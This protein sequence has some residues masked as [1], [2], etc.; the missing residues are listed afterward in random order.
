MRLII[1]QPRHEDQIEIER[2]RHA[3][4][5]QFLILQSMPSSHLPEQLILN[6]TGFNEDVTDFFDLDDEDSSQGQTLNDSG[7]KNSASPDNEV[8]PENRRLV[9]P[10]THL[11]L[12]HPLRKVE[13]RLR[14]I[15]AAGHLAAVHEAVAEKSFQYSHVLR[16]AP[17]K[18]VRTRSRSAIAKL[19]TRLVLYC[20]VYS[21]S[22]AAIVR[23]G[24]DDRT[25]STYRKLSREDVKAS[26]AIMNPN[27]PGASSLRLSWIWLSSPSGTDSSPNGMQECE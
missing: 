3:L 12:N 22:R 5:A 8:L 20:R 17:T 18:A 25:L 7:D 9:L 1:K 14:I 11:P 21:R 19:N 4:A 23:L 13:L 15:Q 27:L 6:P 2:L 10:S 16:K 26:S 24:A